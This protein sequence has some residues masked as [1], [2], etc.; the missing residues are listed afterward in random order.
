MIISVYMFCV[1]TRS[2]CARLLFKS[3]AM[4]RNSAETV[5][6][7]REKGGWSVEIEEWNIM[8][9]MSR[10]SMSRFGISRCGIQKR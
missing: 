5:R 9:I 1:G 4:N 10:C 2:V 7:M 3:V 8:S 6:C